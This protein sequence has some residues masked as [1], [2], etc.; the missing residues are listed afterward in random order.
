MNT[1]N[2]MISA[3]ERR[4]SDRP[5]A[6]GFDVSQLQA[7]VGVHKFPLPYAVFKRIFDIAASAFGII[8]VSPL[9]IAVALVIKLTSRGPIFF[10]QVR[11]GMGGKTFVMY[12][13]RTMVV[14]AE[15]RKKE[16]MKLNEQSGP[17]FKMKKDPRI[18][19]VG[20]FLRRYS[21]D[22]LP[23]LINVLRGEMSVVGPR[24]PLL[25][26]VILYKKW[27]LR[28]LSVKPGLTCIWQTSGRSNVDFA[29]WVRMDIRY[30]DQ[31]SVLLD[32]VLV[33]KTFRAVVRAEG[34]F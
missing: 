6:E 16:L 34:A 2:A 32:T 7:E 4:R 31:A 1:A 20:G 11:V 17:V 27:Q 29:N 22:E 14:D 25:S 18:T 13:F 5:D 10:R 9:L 21:I 23:Q 8:A 24:P 12:K 30:I 28:R 3:G 15:A 26:E 19:K 33:V